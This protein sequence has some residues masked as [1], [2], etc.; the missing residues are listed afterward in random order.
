MKDQLRVVGGGLTGIGLTSLLG[1]LI[2]TQA[3][4]ARDAPAW[5]YWLCSAL[6]AVGALM[7]LAGQSRSM[8]SDWQEYREQVRAIAPCDRPRDRDAE[9]RQMT[10]FCRG[11]GSYWWWQAGPWAGK[12]ALLATFALT[13]PPG[14]TVVSFFI[15]SSYAAQRDSTA[16]ASAVSAQLED[17]LRRGSVPVPTGGE[18]GPGRYW[19]L[20]RHA[21]RHC[22]QHGRRLVLV[23]DGLD[24]D[25]GPGEGRPSIASLL[26]KHC[27]Y[28]LKVIVASRLH[29]PVPSDVPADHP[30]RERDLPHAL[31]ASEHARVIRDKAQRELRAI[32]NGAACQKELLGFIAAADGGLTIADL[33]ELT[34]QAPHQISDSLGG[35]AARVFTTRPGPWTSP[36][37]QDGAVYL[38]AHETLHAE[39][40]TAL[41]EREVSDYRNRIHAWAQRYAA[42]GWPPAT[43][44]YLLRDYF[45][46]ARDNRDT[47]HVLACAT[48]PAR[49]ER[50]LHRTGSDT[51]TLAEIGAAT[52]VIL[53]QHRPDLA[54]MTR[55][56][57][58]REALTR[59]NEH[60]P[61]SL[62][63]VWAALGH[64]ARAEALAHCI[65]N[66]QKR[67]RALTDVSRA[68]A[69]AGLTDQA[70]AAAAQAAAT[71]STITDHIW[72][73]PADV[74]VAYQAEEL[75]AAAR[76]LAAAGLPEQARHAAAQAEAVVRTI[77]ERDSRKPRSLSGHSG[78]VLAVAIAPFPDGTIAVISGSS[79]HTLRMSRLTDGAPI[80][81][82]TACV[83]DGEVQALA[84][85]ALPDGTPVIISGAADATVRVWR[86][87]E[88]APLGPPITG[89]HGPVLAVATGTLTDGTSVIVS[90]GADTTVRVWRLSDH[91]PLVLQQRPEMLSGVAA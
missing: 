22:E 1:Y 42:G 19:L 60:M 76:A 55:L 11:T 26:P 34:G 82:P 78:A 88:H 41:G 36:D 59:R 53:A 64:P 81:P 6:T 58:Y 37:E 72:T 25:H 16:F 13:P 38:M 20:L 77:P 61:A 71:A 49:H 46:M 15:T 69:A 21:A 90:G 44:G 18:E 40:I 10:E 14:L 30:L 5:P 67:A 79:D 33:A 91:A 52:A 89:N 31:G 86:L 32:L 24:E 87:T 80:C 43:P 29:P 35:A 12:S 48:D 39:A 73:D 2:A 85:G 50:L 51:A 17:L 56:A 66:P 75:A 63:A 83:H 3:S 57:Y 70:A 27:E 4:N 62:P 8:R 47:R 7:Y 45:Q 68:L 9:L 54:D 65:T 74:V 84:V 28:G 23:V